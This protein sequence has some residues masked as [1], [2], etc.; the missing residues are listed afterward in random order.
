MGLNYYQRKDLL[1][2]A[3]YTEEDFKMSKKEGGKAKLNRNIIRSVVSHY[4]LWKA[5][6]AVESARRK[7]KRLVKG[8]HW[9]Q[10]KSLY[11]K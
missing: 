1:W 8:D 7:F 9:K 10:Q 6:E 4:P 11:V 5:E 3:G 2:N